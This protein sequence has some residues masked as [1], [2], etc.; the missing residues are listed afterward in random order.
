MAGGLTALDPSRKGIQLRLGHGDEGAERHG[1]EGRRMDAM[2]V[3][4]RGRRLQD[5]SW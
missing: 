2:S 1:D 4:R 5:W 3:A